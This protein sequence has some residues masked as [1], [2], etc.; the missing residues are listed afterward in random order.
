MPETVTKDVSFSC[1]CTHPGITMSDSCSRMAIGIF[2]LPLVVLVPTPLKVV[3]LSV[4]PNGFKVQDFHL[5]FGILSPDFR[6][7]A[8][9]TSIVYNCPTPWSTIGSTTR[10]LSV[11]LSLK[12]VG[13][14]RNETNAVD[15]VVARSMQFRKSWIAIDCSK[16]RSENLEIWSSIILVARSICRFV[17]VVPFVTRSASSSLPNVLSRER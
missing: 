4:Y 17:I 1:E 10:K 16:S 9:V 8:T 3:R 15:G 12:C 11:W 14:S 7:T 5:C 6:M 13:C 2:S